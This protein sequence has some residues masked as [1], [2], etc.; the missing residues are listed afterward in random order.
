GD[1]DLLVQAVRSTV[2]DTLYLQETYPPL[3][4]S[5]VRRAMDMAIDRVA[6]N[7]VLYRRSGTPVRSFLPPSIRFPVDVF[8]PSVTRHDPA[9]ARK[10]LAQAGYPNGFRL[11]LSTTGAISGRYG[12]DFLVVIGQ[13]LGTIGIRATVDVVGRYEDFRSS[14]AAGKL[15]AVYARSN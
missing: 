5:L 10:L 1:P 8:R 9:A 7:E 2:N 11:T 13:A 12:G 3:A 4:S 15:Q 14:N 6:L